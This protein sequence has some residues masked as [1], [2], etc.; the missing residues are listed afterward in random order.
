MIFFFNPETFIKEEIGRKKT[1][2]YTNKKD[3]SQRESKCLNK[4]SISKD[5][6]FDLF[7]TDFYA[8]L[9]IS[10]VSNL[11]FLYNEKEQY[12]IYENFRV[13]IHKMLL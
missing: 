9:Q 2:K 5:K 8:S 13:S 1:I 7:Q 10:I 3:K 4:H 6:L 11:S 12:I